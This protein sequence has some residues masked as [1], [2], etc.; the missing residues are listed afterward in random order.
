MAI[1]KFSTIE[2]AYCHAI[3]DFYDPL[4]IA[5][6]TALRRLSRAVEAKSSSEL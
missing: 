6:D 3:S 2:L 1:N 4:L 5:A